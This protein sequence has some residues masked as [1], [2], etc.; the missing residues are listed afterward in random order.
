MADQHVEIADY[1]PAWADR[2]ARQQVVV[3]GLLRPWSSRPVEHIGSTSVP[4]LRAKPVIDMLALVSSLP[5]ARDA[6]P[7]LADAG[8]LFWPEDPC[9]HYRLWLL[10]PRPEARTHHLH[11]VEAGHPHARALLAF[12][13]ALRSDAGLRLEYASLK[14]R[15]AEQHSDNRNAYTNAKAA[16]VERTLQQAGINP[17]PRDLLP[18]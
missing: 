4:G 16:F 5:A 10:R 7:V 18:E 1:D 13:N 8:W 12:R 3:E 17:P 14:E 2:F 9:G 15:L 11:V 6:L